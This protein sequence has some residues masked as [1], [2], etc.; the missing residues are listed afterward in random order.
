MYNYI[1]KKEKWYNDNFLI[2]LNDKI[3][4]RFTPSTFKNTETYTFDDSKYI[5]KPKNIWATERF[6]IKND[7]TIG[8]IKNF[9]AKNNSTISIFGKTEYY[10]NSH[11]LKSNQEILKEGKQTGILRNKFSYTEINSDEELEKEILSSLIS[12]THYENTAFLVIFI[13]IF[14]TILT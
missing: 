8:L 1:I 12:L 6:I 5:I 10:L 9:V 14:I 4:G 11:I 7:E 3:I 2:I 13:V